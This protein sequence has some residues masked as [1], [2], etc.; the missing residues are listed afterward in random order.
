MSSSNSILSYGALRN[1]NHRLIN[2]IKRLECVANWL[3]EESSVQRKVIGQLKIL[4][5]SLRVISKKPHH[6]GKNY[7]DLRHFRC[8]IIHSRFNFCMKNSQDGR[9]QS[10]S[11]KVLHTRMD[12][13][14]GGSSDCKSAISIKFSTRMEN[15]S[16]DGSS[17]CNPNDSLVI[18]RLSKN[19]EMLQANYGMPSCLKGN[20]L[21]ASCDEILVQPAPSLT[22]SATSSQHTKSRQV[23]PRRFIAL[24]PP[25]RMLKGPKIKTNAFSSKQVNA[26]TSPDSSFDD[27]TPSSDYSDH[28]ENLGLQVLSPIPHAS[29][30]LRESLENLD[31]DTATAEPDTGIDEVLHGLGEEIL[32]QEILQCALEYVAQNFVDDNQVDGIVEDNSCNNVQYDGCNDFEEEYCAE[33]GEVACDDFQNVAYDGFELDLHANDAEA[34]DGFCSYDEE[35]AWSME[36]DCSQ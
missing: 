5:Q 20:I 9:D 17:K 34:Y 22:C 31:V 18:K 13:S 24:G 19:I 28:D 33:V 23:I 4:N 3:R 32:G 36:E 35:G 7:C 15:V 12:R 14:F 25:P 29:N 1:E 10:T 2:E 8:K 21:V 16:N 26:E 27:N 11:R 6:F 30:D